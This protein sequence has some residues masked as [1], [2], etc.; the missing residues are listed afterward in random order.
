MFYLIAPFAVLLA[1]IWALVV[2]PSFRIAVLI[3]L[4]LCV[5]A[6]YWA[7]DRAAQE[8]KQE[9]HKE[10]E[11]VA[12]EAERKEYCQAEQKRWTIVSPSQIELRGA[13]LKQPPNDGI[14]DKYDIAASVKNN[15]NSKVTA[16][17]LNVSA[18]DCP[19]LNA[20]VAD[21][22]QIGSGD[23]TIE[24]DIPAGE[25]RQI[26][27]KI[28]LHPGRPRGVLTKRSDVYAVRVTLDQSDNLAAN[29]ARL[30]WVYKCN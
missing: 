13:S 9:A 16:L 27:G 14:N 17:R 15:S 7:R 29:D 1:F 18:L 3:L 26:T 20:R 22:D 4:V 6:F 25:V 24:I 21:C 8:Q 12:F 30:T 23:E 2:F 19:K 11:R 5:G 10:Q 28:T